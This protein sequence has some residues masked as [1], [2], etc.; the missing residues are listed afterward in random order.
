MFV[1]PRWQLHILVASQDTAALNFANDTVHGAV[2][3]EQ[4]NL[5]VVN[6][7]QIVGLN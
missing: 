6:I 7:N 4:N 3:D 1:L 5:S 2:E